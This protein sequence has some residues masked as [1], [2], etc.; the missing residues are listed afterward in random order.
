MQ[1]AYE[2][3]SSHSAGFAYATPAG[4]VNLN[5]QSFLGQ[6]LMASRARFLRTETACI[7]KG[8]EIS[9]N[10][11]G[12]TYKG[13]GSGCG[14]CLQ[15]A[16]RAVLGC[17][18]NDAQCNPIQIGQPK[19]NPWLFIRPRG[20]TGVGLG[21][22]SAKF[23]SAGPRL[24]LTRFLQVRPYW[25]CLNSRLPSFFHSTTERNGMRPSSLTTTEYI[26]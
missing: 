19:K 4:A 6:G 12:A 11:G 17:P 26:P 21:Q 20:V 10:F 8:K 3:A 18:L 22:A 24:Y 5:V 23:W 1:I 25:F 2:P 14:G 7:G 13:S 16:E 15:A 9:F